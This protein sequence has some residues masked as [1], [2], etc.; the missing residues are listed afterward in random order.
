MS[1]LG[2]R[3]ARLS[4]GG[5]EWPPLAPSTIKARRKGKGKGK[6]AI[7]RDVGLLYNAL[8]PTLNSPGAINE[9]VPFGVRVGYG[10]PMRH[11]EGRAT[12]ADIASYHQRG[13][14]RLP[15]RKIIVPPDGST[16]RGM[17]SDARR[18]LKKI[19]DGG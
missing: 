12:I 17:M 19:T 14:G 7:L 4:R 2:L 6:P 8:S 16:R 18:A 13:V 3:F 5:G 9:R 1:F 11:G 10:G 15:Q